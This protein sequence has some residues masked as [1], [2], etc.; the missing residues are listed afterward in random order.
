MTTGPRKPETL[1]NGELAS[2]LRKRHPRWNRESL[3]AESTGVLRSGLK[4][5]DILVME[6][7][8]WPVVV[9]TEFAP[10][11]SRLGAHI[12]RS[13][14]PI[15]GVIA[16]RLPTK[17]KSDADAKLEAVRFEWIGWRRL[18]TKVYESRQQKR[19]GRLRDLPPFSGHI[20]RL[21]EGERRP[22]PLYAEGFPISASRIIVNIA[23]ASWS[24]PST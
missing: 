13:G 22:V 3:V 12:A 15:E 2:A 20:R 5:P 24:I 21:P 9:E 14:E 18:S 4:R 16:V 17:L 7:G 19:G 23:P 6:T 10:A 8:R 11:R 1:V